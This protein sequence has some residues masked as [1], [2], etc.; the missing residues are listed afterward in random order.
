MKRTKIVLAILMAFV[1]ASGAFAQAKATLTVNASEGPAQVILNGRLLGMANPT[2]SAQVTLGTYELI[3]RKT[4]LAEF[5]QTITVG[6]GGLTVNARLGSG[7]VVTPP[8][9]TRYSLTVNANVTGADVYVNGVLAGKTPFSSQV[10]AGSYTVVV[11]AP[12]YNDYTQGINV[13]GNA[14]VNATLSGN[15]SLSVQSNVGGADV[16]INGMMVGKTPYVSQLTEGSYTVVVKANGY[17]DFSQVVRVNGATTVNANLVQAM[18]Q[19]NL[20]KLFPGAEI[21]LNGNK[22][23]VAGSNPFITQ[24]APGTYTLTIRAGGY[25]EFSVQIT[26]GPGGYSYTPVLQ[27]LTA[28]YTFQIPPAI[29]NPDMH[30]NPWSQIRVYIDGV[31]QKDFKGQIQ[32]GKHTLRM[33]TGALQIEFIYDFV[34]G[35]SYVIEPFAGI[36]V[37]E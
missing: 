24:V 3:V 20:G 16:Y 4:G 7:T 14:V 27:P 23:G 25:M 6:A 5:K 17:N 10:P 29:L 22:I 31:A 28:S 9:A 37:R 11:K 26:V 8:P 21:F 13:T 18:V 34:A 30:G 32:P 12:G 33:V 2:F 19:L 35:K 15:S 36:T 1:L